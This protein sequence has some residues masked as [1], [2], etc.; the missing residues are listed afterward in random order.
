[1]SKAVMIREHL[2]VLAGPKKVIAAVLASDE[3]LPI[4]SVINRD[5]VSDGLLSAMAVTIQSTT[6]S[7]GLRLEMGSSGQINLSLEKGDIVLKELGDE[8]TLCLI[9]EKGAN[10]PYFEI[11]MDKAARQLR[12]ILFT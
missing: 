3:G 5:G 12:K 4:E 2:E 10:L 7:V 6:N 11:Q 1:M 9:L 8:I